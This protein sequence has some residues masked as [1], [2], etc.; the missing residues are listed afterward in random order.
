VKRL[1]SLLAFVCTLSA[2]CWLFT[3]NPVTPSTPDGGFADASA[4]TKF[5]DCTDAAVHTAVLSVLPAVETALALQDYEVELAKLVGKFGLDEVACAVA[6]V[7]DKARG[8]YLNTG[9]TLEMQKANNG[10]GWLAKQSV[11]FSP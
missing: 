5:V 6:W 1:A 3:K 10:R 7:V 11:R 8:Q 9:D 4:N 2:G